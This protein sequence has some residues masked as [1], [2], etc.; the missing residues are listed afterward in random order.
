M[1]NTRCSCYK[2]GT[3]RSERACGSPLGVKLAY[4]CGVVPA[5][6]TDNDFSLLFKDIWRKGPTVKKNGNPTKKKMSRVHLQCLLESLFLNCTHGFR[7]LCCLSTCSIAKTLSVKSIYRI[8]MIRLCNSIR[9]FRIFCCFSTCSIAKTLSV[10]SI[11]LINMI[12]LCNSIRGLEITGS[13]IADTL[14]RATTVATESYT[15]LFSSSL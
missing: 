7:I 3:S 10:K 11:Y 5:P 8:N 13:D 15:S 4:C 12:R 14:S 2:E 6:K 1:K 9:G